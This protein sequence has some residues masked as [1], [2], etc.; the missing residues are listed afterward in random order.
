MKGEGTTDDQMISEV[1]FAPTVLSLAGVPIPSYMQG[2]AFLGNQKSNIPRKYCFAGRDRMD[3]EYDRVRSVRDDRYRYVYNYEPEKPYYQNLEYRLNIPSMK[4]ILELKEEGKLDPVTMTWFNTKP[5][6]ELYDEVNDPYD[7]HNLA[8]DPEYNSKLVELQA[9]F[10]NWTS[11]VGDLSSQPE[12][13]MLKKMWNGADHPPVT[14]T[15]EITSNSKGIRISCATQGA[16][17][18]YRIIK[19]GDSHNEVMKPV[20]SYD[21]GVV[22]NPSREGKVEALKPS[23]MVYKNGDV[24]H[25]D[26]GDTLKV[27]AMRIGYTPATA[28]YSY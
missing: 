17:I 5:V 22:N 10:R 12:K 15:P 7:L 26:K 4:E 20:I 8:K 25:L 9:A 1:D 14:A 27:N 13:E 11:T 21:F 18:G 23:W 16:S 24:I 2:Q 19:P 28:D 6:E 3:T